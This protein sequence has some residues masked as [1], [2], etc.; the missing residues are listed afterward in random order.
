[1]F[2]PP[3]LYWLGAGI[4]TTGHV[5]RDNHTVRYDD[6]YGRRHIGVVSWIDERPAAI[7]GMPVR[8]RY[9]SF[10][11]G[12]SW[13][14]NEEWE[15]WRMSLFVPFLLFVFLPL[16]CLWWITIVRPGLEAWRAVRHGSG[17]PAQT[18][19]PAS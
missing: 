6:I 1:M 13:F 18:S 14:V 9:L 4:E 16:V 3:T 17:D 8:V 15:T 5:M 2:G 7:W 12:V 19:E 11:P 10:A